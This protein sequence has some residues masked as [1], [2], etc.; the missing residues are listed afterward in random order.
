MLHVDRVPGGRRFGLDKDIGGT[1]V[2]DTPDYTTNYNYVN[3]YTVLAC[4]KLRTSEFQKFD[5]AEVS[6]ARSTATPEIKFRNA[7]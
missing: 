3:F 5:R 6:Y 4:C 1:P 7:F 2:R